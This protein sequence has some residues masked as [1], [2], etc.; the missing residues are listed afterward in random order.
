MRAGAVFLQICALV[1]LFS[2]S[3]AGVRAEPYFAVREGLKCSNC[4]FNAAGGGMRNAFG[5]GW[6]QTA[7]PAR[8]IEGIESDAW[9]GVVNRF[10]ALGGNLRANATHTDV[11]DNDARSEFDLEEGRAYLAITP[12]PDRLAV[13]FDQRFAPGGSTNLEAF[14]RYTTEDQRWQVQAGQFYLPYGLRLEDDGAFIRQVT[15]INFATPDRGVQV[16]YESG[17]LST[18]LAV[19]NGTASGPEPDEGKQ[20]SLRAEHVQ[21]V[22]RV[23]AGFNLNHTDA[24]DRQMQGVFAGLRTGPI[25]WLA[26]ADYLTDETLGPEERKQWVGLIEANWWI[27]QGHNLKLTAEVFEPDTDVDEDEQNRYSLVY[28]LFPFQFV[29]L[30]LGARIYDG[31]PQ[32][33]LQNRKLFFAQLHGFF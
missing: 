7:L 2:A 21:R 25:A 19:S 12:I 1:A 18:Q 17:S 16:G 30:R 14:A 11:P 10:F 20:V 13:Y 24:G 6:A 9:T 29:Q 31:I 3:V 32:N 4:H 27:S 28:E 8:R 33:D 26:E 22:W 23:G 5:N 15:G